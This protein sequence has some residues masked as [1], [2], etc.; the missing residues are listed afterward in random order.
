MKCTA[1]LFAFVL[2]AVLA[3][4][5]NL[6]PNP[7]FEE[8]T[9]CPS[10]PISNIEVEKAYPW[11]SFKQTPDYFHP[12][13]ETGMMSSPNSISFGY[14]VP[15]HGVAKAGIGAVAWFFNR[16]VLGIE[17]SAPLEIGTEYTVSFQVLR[18]FGGLY[19][20]NC[21]CATNN[22]GL[23]FTTSAYS[24]S[25][26]IPIDNLAHIVSTSVV[27][28]TTNWTEISGVFT[29]DSAYTH[30]AIGVFF[31]NDHIIVENYNNYDMGYKAYYFVD[32]V[33]ISQ[34][35][36][37]CGALR[38]SVVEKDDQAPR[39]KVYPNPSSDN[40]FL[41]SDIR[42]S[43]VQIIDIFGRTIISE[44]DWG[45]IGQMDIKMLAKGVYILKV[46]FENGQIISKKLIKQ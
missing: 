37:D 3:T 10:D 24:V 4:G 43:E 25:N 1:L 20:A 2:P 31:D 46:R 27:S 6:V 9:E 39:L 16:E 12:C 15:Y 36:N 35:P 13:D 5:Q 32:A 33:C 22:V 28:D 14:G 40:L 29:A 34:D 18:T 8:F 44:H 30:L 11:K 19:N 41:E 23:K 7:S 42:M 17:L 38:P 45:M 21:D 26:P